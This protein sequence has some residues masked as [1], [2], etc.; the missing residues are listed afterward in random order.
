MSKEYDRISNYLIQGQPETAF[1]L[2]AFQWGQAKNSQA[3]H[4]HARI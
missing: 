1:F 2:Q 3:L 4:R